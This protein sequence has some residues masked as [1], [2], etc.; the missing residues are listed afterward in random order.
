MKRRLYFL[1][2]DT[3]HATVVVK[4]L[5]VHGI[6]RNRMHAIAGQGADLGDLPVASRN[7]RR[8]LAAR[9]ED[10]VWGGNLGLFFVA[11]LALVTMIALPVNGYWLLLP[12]GIMLVSF[13]IG[14]EFA[15]RIPN[16]HL[17]EFRDAMRH[18]EILL[19]IDVPLS[20]VTRVEELVHRHH[21]EAVVGGVGWSVD[22]MQI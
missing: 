4:E 11:L 14:L 15:T 19:M 8:D 5:E 9:I 7:Q 1:F 20:Q 6:E 18:R 2:P 22:A 21:P 17:A 16:V 12:A 10:V 13:L 3:G